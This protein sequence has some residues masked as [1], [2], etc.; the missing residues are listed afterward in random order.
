LDGIIYT[1]DLTSALAGITRDTIVTLARD[2][3]YKVIEKRITRDE[4]YCAGPHR[5]HL[6]MLLVVLTL[7]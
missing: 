4:V 2:L 3:G 7:S 1:P 5:S 6:L